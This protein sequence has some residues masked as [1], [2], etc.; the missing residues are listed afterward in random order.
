MGI[1]TK[2]TIYK[3]NINNFNDDNNTNLYFLINK[4]N[5]IFLKMDIEGANI[6]GY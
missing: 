1:Y 2:Y 6:H 3:K 4:Y 5:N